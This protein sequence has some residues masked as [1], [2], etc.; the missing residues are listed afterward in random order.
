[1]LVAKVLGKVAT[2]AHSVPR[3]ADVRHRVRVRR[4][5]LETG[6]IVDVELPRN[7][8][9]AGCDGGGCDTCDRSG[10]ITLRGR[11]EPAEVVQVTLPQAAAANESVGIVLRIPEQG[12]LPKPEFASLPRGLLLLTVVPSDEADP[13]VRPAHLSL[14]RPAA[15]PHAPGDASDALPA[16]SPKRD[17][18]WLWVAIGLGAW[19]MFLLALRFSGCR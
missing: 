19:V 17:R 11:S 3:G 4:E 1:M 6:L 14:Q 5:W 13:A 15:A 9:C 2:G 18:L 16:L 7:L 12:G 10:A 8:V